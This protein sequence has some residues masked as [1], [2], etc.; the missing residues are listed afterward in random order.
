MRRVER[1][2]IVGDIPNF[3][4]KPHGDGW[5]LVGDASYHKDP[6]L[7]QGISD[8]F[9]SARWLADAIHLSSELAIGVLVQVLASFPPSPLPVHVLYSHTRQLSRR[10]RLFIDWIAEQF[11]ERLS[12]AG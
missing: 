2:R 4:R 11:R 9:R 10:Q 1:I 3:L 8:A 6:I 7:A 5:A 12:R